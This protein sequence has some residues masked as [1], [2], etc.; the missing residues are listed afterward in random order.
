PA[1]SCV[2]QLVA[3]A[4]A[5]AQSATNWSTQDGAGDQSADATA[6]DFPADVPPSFGGTAL[7]VELIRFEASIKNDEIVVVWETA[8]ELNND[9]FE[10]HKSSNGVDFNIVT[11]VNGNGTSSQYQRY[12]YTDKE[13]ALNRFVYYRL[14]QVDY[15]GQYEWFETILVKLNKI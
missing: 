1:P 13:T 7:P 6:P 5:V 4:I 12:E 14:K 9:Y 15:D 10:L 2:D 8:S 11:Q 3:V